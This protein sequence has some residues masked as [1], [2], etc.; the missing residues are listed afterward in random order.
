MLVPLPEVVMNVGQHQSP[1]SSTLLRSMR[2]NTRGEAQP[3]C[4]HEEGEA[5]WR[6]DLKQEIVAHV[7]F[8]I[9]WAMGDESF[10]THTVPE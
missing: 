8:E 6:G 5:D 1:H 4:T 2:R 7:V 9:L 3:A 10:V